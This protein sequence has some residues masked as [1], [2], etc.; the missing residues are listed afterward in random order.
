MARRGN[1]GNAGAEVAEVMSDAER[2]DSAKEVMAYNPGVIF[3]DDQIRDIQ[4]FDDL[5]KLFQAEGV[6]VGNASD[7]GDGFSIL[8]NKDKLLEIPFII[9]DWRFVEG[10]H[11]RFVTMRIVTQDAKRY[12]VN[13]GSTGICK[14]LDEY[15]ERSKSQ[16]GFM[17]PKGLTVSHYQY[18][19]PDGS[20]KDAETYYLSTQAA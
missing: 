11:G 13:D 9:V 17:V 4:S 12:R 20:M 15:T 18:A 19:A 3:T 8:D 16:R 10:D 7:L 6:T 1:Q 14:Q 2:G 5:A